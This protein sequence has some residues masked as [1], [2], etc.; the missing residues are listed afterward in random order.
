MTNLTARFGAPTRVA[1]IPRLGDVLQI[2]TDAPGANH[3]LLGGYDANFYLWKFQIN[4]GRHDL[5]RRFLRDGGIDH[6]S[7]IAF[8]GQEAQ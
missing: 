7:D 6:A 3:A 2:A 4:S 8:A 5:A 1:R